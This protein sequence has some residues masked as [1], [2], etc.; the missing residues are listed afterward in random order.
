M[1]FL[2]HIIGLIVAFLFSALG[3]VAMPMMPTALH[4]A[5][6]FPHQEAVIVEHRD[7]HFA[8]RAPPLAARNVAFTG[9]AVAEHGNGIIMYGH[10]THVASLG[11]GVGFDAPNNGVP[12]SWTQLNPAGAQINRPTGFTTYRTPDGDMVHVSPS[13]LQYGA[14]PKFGNRVDHVLDHTAPNPS[15]PV[16][17]VFNAQG[18]D[19][20]RIVDDAWVNRTG[21]GTLQSNGNRTWTVD[22]G[23]PIGTNGQTSIQIVVRDGTNEII[24][25][26]PK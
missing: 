3:A 20:L 17:S 6:F 24:T 2:L 25:A 18:D 11:F 10:E 19:A 12:S 8:A 26:F 9:A 15:K 1:G 4:Q 7:V 5:E 21:P 14:D 22:L 16:H 23:R 13:G